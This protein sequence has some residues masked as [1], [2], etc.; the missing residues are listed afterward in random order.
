VNGLAGG[1]T[2]TV[3]S[4]AETITGAV[5]NSRNVAGTG[6]S[7]LTLTGLTASDISF[8]GALPGDYVVASTAVG[9][10]TITPIPLTVALGPVTK[11]YDGTTGVALS[12]PNF[13]ITGFVNGETASVINATGTYGNRNVLGSGASTVFSLIGAANFTSA[14]ADFR[15]GNY[16]FNSALTNTVSTI[17]PATLTGTLAAQTKVYDGNTT[18]AGLTTA[19]Y[20]LNGLVH[21][22][23]A[24]VGATSGLYNN[25][26]VVGATTVTAAGLTAADYTAGAGTLGTTFIAA[27]YVLPTAISGAGTITPKTIAGAII[28][29]PTKTYDGTAA[30]T[31]TQ[32]NYALTGFVGAD[33]VTVGQT[34]GTYQSPNAN[35]V[36]LVSDP[37]TANPV[38]FYTGTG[39]TVLSN[40]AL[41][42][43]LSGAGTINPKAIAASIV[44]DPTKVYDS[45]VTAALLPAN[46]ALTGFVGPDGAAVNQSVGTYN[47]KD[48]PTATSVTA[49]LGPGSLTLTGGALASNYILPTT[50]TGAAAITPA[51]LTISGLTAFDK[52]YDGTTA[53]T[54]DAT[55]AA[56]LTGVYAGDAVAL[57][58]GPTSATFASPNVGSAI[59]VRL[60]GASITG[61]DA[62]D[63]TL[64]QAAAITAAITPKTLIATIVG[65]PTKTY[66]GTTVATLSSSDY[67]L[68][69]FV[70]GQTGSVVQRA[71]TYASP[72]AGSEGVTAVLG[73][74]TITAGAGTLLS[75]YSLPTIA[76][77]TGLIN[78]A[79][80]SATIVGTPTKTY[81]GTTGA[82]LSPANYVL[83]G[84][85]GGD[86]ST[87]TQTSGTYAAATVGPETV[88]ATLTA[89]NFTPTGGTLIGNYRLPTTASGAG[90]VT[91]AA[92][93]TSSG[94]VAGT[95]IVPGVPASSDL[96]GNIRQAIFALAD[97]RT[98]IPYPAPGAL[99]TWRNN[100]WGSLP[101][102]VGDTTDYSRVQD[103]DGYLA[104]QSGAPVIN[105][106]EQVM[107]QGV[108][109]KRWR[110]TISQ[111]AT[112]PTLFQTGSAG[113]T[114]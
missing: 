10:G 38:G 72:N 59:S 65:T 67:A 93:G 44:G 49:A 106:T 96:L 91:P 57:A 28:G 50:A 52:V 39:S 107:L 16:T 75:N 14:D 32:A 40:Y 80:L 88:T 87:V 79:Q 58:T 111:F 104:V 76:I 35:G 9:A 86:G 41:P 60:G 19:S 7:G 61:A 74:G 48:V 51:P 90:L 105:T 92:S 102:V 66:D 34:S 77:G 54:L 29:D 47:S 30:S 15:I 2:V 26:N 110:I 53:A 25:P 55:H 20:T 62:G 98:Y 63:Y 6:G 23:T 56:A 71:G 108:K 36:T 33:G 114:Q 84:F 4:D 97:P 68:T 1:D 112:G 13:S 95:L 5:F 89:A 85:V 17:T 64:S 31:L 22:E 70:A 46:Y 21:G 100:S 83:T 24:T 3:K 11:T 12:S 45:T 27:N 43:T 99:S 37:V 73:G 103:D 82:T 81:D 109:N 78:P 42:T 69:G 8:T 18:A 113:G 101:I 94:G